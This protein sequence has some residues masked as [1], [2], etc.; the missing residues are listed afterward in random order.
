MQ[1]FFSKYQ[2]YDKFTQSLTKYETSIIQQSSYA[3]IFE[4]DAEERRGAIPAKIQMDET[5]LG[6]HSK[7][8]RM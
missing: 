5:P 2:L 3:K 6:R 8:S 4:L 1:F 7:T